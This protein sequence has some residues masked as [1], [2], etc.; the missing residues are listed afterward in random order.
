MKVSFSKEES[1]MLDSVSASPSARRVIAFAKGIFKGTVVSAVV[2]QEH[3]KPSHPT[4]RGRGPILTGSS[5]PYANPHPTESSDA[6][7]EERARGKAKRQ[8]HR[9]KQLGFLLPLSPL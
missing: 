4:L 6:L 7:R 3:E 2:L 9:E 1:M 8:A 5:G